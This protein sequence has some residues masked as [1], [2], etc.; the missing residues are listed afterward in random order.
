M[1]PITVARRCFDRMTERVTQIQNGAQA[2]LALVDAD[3][4]GFD[5]TRAAHCVNHGAVDPPQQSLGVALRATTKNA[6][7]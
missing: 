7:S 2:M 4:F 6:G 1:Q 5:L 3:D